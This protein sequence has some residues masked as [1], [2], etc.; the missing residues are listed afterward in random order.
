MIYW[1]VLMTITMNI[2]PI[3]E[4]NDDGAKGDDVIFS[5]K[6]IMMI[7][8]DYADGFDCGVDNSDL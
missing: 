5:I 1:T 8:D 3:D 4:N 2:M 6:I 7:Y